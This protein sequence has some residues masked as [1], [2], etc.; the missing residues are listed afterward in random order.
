MTTDSVRRPMVSD[1]KWASGHD[2]I[3]MATNRNRCQ[4]AGQGYCDGTR[5]SPEHERKAPAEATR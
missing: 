4:Y 1:F 3:P 5:K 2:F